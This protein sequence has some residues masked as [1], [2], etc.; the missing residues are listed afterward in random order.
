M[1]IDFIF[2]INHTYLPIL[3]QRN[4][5]NSNF[6]K[7][8]LCKNFLWIMKHTTTIR[9]LPVFNYNQKPLPIPV[10]HN[11][12]KPAQQADVSKIQSK[13]T[14]TIL[15][16]GELPLRQ[17]SRSGNAANTR[18]SRVHWRTDSGPYWENILQKW[19]C[20]VWFQPSRRNDWA[21]HSLAME[22]VIKHLVDRQIYHSPRYFFHL[23]LTAIK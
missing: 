22:K 11:G 21:V 23:S 12:K 2:A 14:E 15:N 6:C 9:K 10:S 20:E 1:Y 3:Q 13:V 18:S 19:S 17:V 4:Q 16:A 5:E 8:R 7:F